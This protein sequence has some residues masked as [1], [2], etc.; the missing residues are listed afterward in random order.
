MVIGASLFAAF[1]V[2]YAVFLPAFYIPVL[3]LLIGLIFRGVAFEFRNR[4]NARALWN[5]GFFLGS[6]V[7]AFVQG[8]AV[9]QMIRG[10]PVIANQYVG[11]PFDWLAPLPV[12]TGIGLVLGYSLLG[13]GWLVLN[14]RARCATGRGAASRCSPVQCWWYSASPPSPLLRSAPVS[15][16]TSFSAGLGALSFRSSRSWQSMACSSARAAGATLGHS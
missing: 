16:A 3:L 5:Q 6:A 11:G 9:G 2:V 12:L 8:A 1:P 15:P 7:V 13:A 4:D 14:P 10:I